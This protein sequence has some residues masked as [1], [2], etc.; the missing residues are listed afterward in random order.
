MTTKA[1]NVPLENLRSPC[2][3]PNFFMLSEG[4]P[5]PNKNNQTEFSVINQSLSETYE[6]LE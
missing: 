3:C 1:S 6:V 2:E 5:S 4:V